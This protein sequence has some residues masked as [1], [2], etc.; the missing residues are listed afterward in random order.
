MADYT[1][2]GLV[3][4]SDR[5]LGGLD[6]APDGAAVDVQ[7]TLGEGAPPNAH[8]EDLVPYHSGGAHAES[9]ADVRRDTAG[10]FWFRYSDDTCFVLDPAGTSIRA[11]WAEH[12]SLEDTATYLLGPV[13][14]FALRRRGVLALHAS[15]II[16]GGRAVAFLGRSGSGK[17]TTAAA[18][19]AEGVP[20]LSDDVV[21]VRT[22]GGLASAYPSYRLLRL[23]DASEQML[24]GTVGQLPLMTPT[25]DKRALPLGDAHPFH[26]APAPL[27]DLF[28]IAPRADDAHAPYV[29]VMRPRVAF[30]EL[31]AN[32][33]ANYLLDDAMR[34]EEMGA[35][36]ALLRGRRV[37]RLVPHADPS[38]L[39]ALVR[40]VR[41]AVDESDGR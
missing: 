30:M 21:A 32:T 15:A 24:F 14:G 29:E 18:F 25:W 36:D 20:V 28:I 27:G 26:A 10:N 13:L 2:Y 12:S 39:E 3:V 17:S 19:A 7:I 23:W 5:P 4:R 9:E 1:L 34:A 16:L 38:R 40:C 35:L 41:D 8:S 6:A 22:I 33:Y 37:R 31:V 11:W